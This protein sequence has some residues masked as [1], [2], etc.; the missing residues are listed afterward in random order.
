MGIASWFNV[1]PEVTQEQLDQEFDLETTVGGGR[2]GGHN[3]MSSMWN[4]EVTHS[5]RAAAALL[6]GVY[7]REAQADEVLIQLALADRLTDEQVAQMDREL[8][9]IGMRER[10]GLGGNYGPPIT[11]TLLSSASLDT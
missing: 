1:E 6:M 9:P 3:D 7:G 2:V 4:F 10:F 5:Q 8:R 11:D